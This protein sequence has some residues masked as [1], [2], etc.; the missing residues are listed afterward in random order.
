VTE[1]RHGGWGVSL[2]QQVADHVTLF[3]RMGLSTRGEAAFDRAVT[4][5]AQFD[6]GLWGRASD[7]IGLAAGWLR[8]SGESGLSGSEKPAELYYVWQ[9]NEHVHLS[10]GMQW[11]GNPGGDKSADDVIVWSLRAKASF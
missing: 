4:V 8:A 2:D 5:G 10:P 11:I 1:E 9:L 7:R 6:G 3:S